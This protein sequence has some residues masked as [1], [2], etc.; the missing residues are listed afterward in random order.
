MYL[1]LYRRFTIGVVLT[2]YRRH[3]RDCF[4]FNKPR[5]AKGA[6]ACK[7]AC[8]IW[9]QGTL[10]GEYIRRSLDLTSWEAASELVQTGKRRV[11]SAL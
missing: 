9:V 4:F 2:L 10:R 6:R 5:H 3:I 7:A 1:I 11:R 8:T